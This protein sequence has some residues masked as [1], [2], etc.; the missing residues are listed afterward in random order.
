M[1]LNPIKLI[2]KCEAHAQYLA[3]IGIGNETEDIRLTFMCQISCSFYLIF[4]TLSANP[5]LTKWR[6]V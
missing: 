5:V 1:R 2:L 4:T 3:G 6:R